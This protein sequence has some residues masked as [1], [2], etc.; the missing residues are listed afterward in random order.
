[1]SLNTPHAHQKANY[2]M[3]MICDW[4]YKFNAKKGTIYCQINL[5]SEWFV[6]T[7]NIGVWPHVLPA[8]KIMVRA[9]C[10]SIKTK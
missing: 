3:I 7:L 4:R 2:F 9:S 8:D 5:K 10:L 6:P 1:M